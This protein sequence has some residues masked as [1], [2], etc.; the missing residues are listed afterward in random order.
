MR[1][2]LDQARAAI[3]AGD[4]NRAERLL[5][6]AEAR[7]LAGIEAAQAA[8]ERR[9]L[10]AAAVRAERAEVLLIRLCYREAAE[11]FAAAAEL[12]PDTKPEQQLAYRWQRAKALYR[13]ASGNPGLPES[14]RS[15]PSRPSAPGLGQDTKQPGQR[16]CKIRRTGIGH[17]MVG[18][19]PQLY[20]GCLACIQGC[21]NG[22]VRRRVPAAFGGAR[23]ADHGATV[24][25]RLAPYPSINVIKLSVT[26]RQTRR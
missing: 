15:I 19:D 26:G 1:T 16:P 3:G 21:R 4:Y 7:E 2:L 9:R 18:G 13:P 17:R 20:R 11:R 22:S 6:Q 12:V 14:A 24:R 10:S 8:V 23:P 5:E 25:P